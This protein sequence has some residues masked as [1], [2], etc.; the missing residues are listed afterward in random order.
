MNTAIQIERQILPGA[1]PYVRSQ[2]R[3]AYANGCKLL[4]DFG[5]NLL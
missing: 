3:S 4:L 1:E 5:I 2:E